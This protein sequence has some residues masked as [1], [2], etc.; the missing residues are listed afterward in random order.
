MFIQSTRRLLALCLATV[1][2]ASVW[3]V[4]SVADEKAGGP[5]APKVHDLDIEWAFTAPPPAVRPWVYW[6][7]LNANVSEASITA[8]LEA[9]AAQGV[10]GFLLFDVTAYG[11][12]IVA[13][14]PRTVEFMS[15]RWRQL[16]RF[17]LEEAHRL[18]LQASINLSTC[19]GA[20]RAPRNMEQHAVKKLVWASTEVDGPAAI[21]LDRPECTAPYFH[22]VAVVAARIG[23]VG[24]PVRVG[25]TSDW[26][27]VADPLPDDAPTAAE[28]VDLSDRVDAAGRLRW[29]APAGRWRVVRLACVVMEERTEDVDILNAQAVEAIKYFSGTATYRKRIELTAAQAAGLIRL[30]LGEVGCIARVRLNGK[31]LGVVWTDPWT[32]DLTGAAAAGENRLE[33]DVANVWQNRLIGDAHLPEAERRTRT[34]VVLEQG[35]RT[36]RFLCSSINTVDALT[37]SGLIGPV[38]LEFGREKI[39]PVE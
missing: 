31:D 4:E 17:A 25:P 24:N 5:V 19:G 7:W 23:P 32:V 20:L 22:P 8:D 39:V 29:Q 11:H 3:V 34:N 21:E 10:G 16:V 27:A 6:W 35:E 37:P 36:R 9:L 14:P 15:P 38:R 2:A 12:H 26:S 13:A 18:G 28:V 33:I 30:R 1:L